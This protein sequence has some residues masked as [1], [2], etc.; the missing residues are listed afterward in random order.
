MGRHDPHTIWGRFLCVEVRSI[1]EAI[2]V[3]R[4]LHDHGDEGMPNVVMLID[5]LGPRGTQDVIDAI[6]SDIGVGEIVLEA[7]GGIRPSEIMLWNDVG[8]DVLSMGA[9]TQGVSPFD[10]SMII[11]EVSEEGMS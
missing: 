10:L 11:D 4:W 2:E 6:H 9:L 5:N 3:G 8:V 7:S 1:P